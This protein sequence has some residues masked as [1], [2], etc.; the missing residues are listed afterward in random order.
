MIIENGKVKREKEI[1]DIITEISRHN[2]QKRILYI[3]GEHHIGKSTLRK[4]L[5][6]CLSKTTGLLDPVSQVFHSIN[7]VTYD[8]RVSQNLSEFDTINA[9]YKSISSKYPYIQFPRYEFGRL[10]LY[11]QYG[12]ISEKYSFEENDWAGIFQGIIKS[13]KKIAQASVPQGSEADAILNNPVSDFFINQSTDYLSKKMNSTKIFLERKFKGI[14]IQ[15]LSKDIE[16]ILS[17]SPIDQ[18]EN[19]LTEYFLLD[20]EAFAKMTSS[21]N[22]II[23]D[24]FEICS[25]R[26]LKEQWFYS[27]LIRASESI[28]WIIF[29]TET[30]AFKNVH[31]EVRRSL[32]PAPYFD[33]S[34]CVWEKYTKENIWKM[35]RFN[36]SVSHIFLANRLPKATPTLINKFI[37]LSQNHPGALGILLDAYKKNDL[38]TISDLDFSYESEDFYP[39]IFKIYFQNSDE[40]ERSILYFLSAFDVWT[41]EIFMFFANQNHIPTPEKYFISITE[42]SFIQKYSN[43]EF[44]IIDLA[45]NALLSNCDKEEWHNNLKI[46]FEYYKTKSDNLL[47][48]WV[49]SQN[50]DLSLYE[51]L[52]T[53][54][55]KA[56]EYGIKFYNTDDEFN[57]FSQWFVKDSNNIVGFEQ[58]LSRPNIQLYD[59]KKVLLTQYTSKIERKDSFSCSNGQIYK[60][61]AYYDLLWA[62]IYLHDYSNAITACSQRLEI[63]LLECSVT[64]EEIIK[65]IYSLGVIYQ[66]WGRYEDAEFWHTVALKQRKLNSV[67]TKQ[68]DY[69]KSIRLVA[70]SLNTL[71]DAKMNNLKNENRFFEARKLF[72]KALKIKKALYQ[73]CISDEQKSKAKKDIVATINNISK[74]YFLW[75]HEEKNIKKIEKAKN[76]NQK[77]IEILSEIGVNKNNLTQYEIREAVADFELKRIENTIDKETAKLFIAKFEKYE[78]IWSA[79]NANKN[80]FNHYLLNTHI[81]M[82]V[83]YAYAEDFDNARELFEESI[84]DNKRSGLSNNFQYEKNAQIAIKNLQVLELIQSQNQKEYLKDLTLIY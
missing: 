45:R 56:V 66:R 68:K 1:N 75:G 11:Q 17:D 48:R 40:I 16:S 65:C 57:A 41:K 58:K 47:D 19:K 42:L 18:I 83:V 20:L 64:D 51:E 21:T 26:N 5:E 7:Y 4:Q 9:L 70:I 33:D 25:N 2:E 10:Y 27:K 35:K 22:I 82:G 61:Q 60:L 37:D 14:T 53:S 54:S 63:G 80:D 67:T 43:T 79:D 29:G 34:D 31:D 44:F 72:K 84:N 55:I 12:S 3:C 52:K 73:N 62:F 71:A 13:M 8:F 50:W 39:E 74:L 30:N 6:N 32:V 23:L 24:T 15:E 76:K 49:N 46:G 38:K 36:R 78:K 77:C 59:L 69:E 81:N 28:T